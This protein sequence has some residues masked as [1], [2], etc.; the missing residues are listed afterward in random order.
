MTFHIMLP[1]GTTLEMAHDIATRLENAIREGMGIEAT[2]HMEPLKDPVNQ[3][4]P[5]DQD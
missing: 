4:P 3:Y 5:V 1:K 2:I